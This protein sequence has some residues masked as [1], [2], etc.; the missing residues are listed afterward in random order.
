MRLD[1]QWVYLDLKEGKMLWV[2]RT[3]GERRDLWDVAE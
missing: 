2:E 1:L 3:R